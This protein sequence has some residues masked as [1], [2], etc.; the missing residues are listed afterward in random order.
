MS[1]LVI[2]LIAGGVTLLAGATSYGIVKAGEAGMFTS[3]DVASGRKRKHPRTH[4]S[5]SSHMSHRGGTSKYRKR[6]KH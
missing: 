6:N 5:H 4:R 3:G 2:G 1:G